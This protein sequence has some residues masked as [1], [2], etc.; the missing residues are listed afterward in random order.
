MADDRSEGP[1]DLEKPPS[2]F[3]YNAEDPIE[4]AIEPG[5]PV[6]VRVK[7]AYA[8]QNGGAIQHFVLLTDG[9]RD[10]PI[11]IG[12]FEAYSISLKLDGVKPDRPIS[13]DLTK[14]I[15]EKLGAKLERIV[16]DDLFGATFYAKLFVTTANE[17]ISIDSRPSD[18]IALALR[19]ECPIFVSDTILEQA[20]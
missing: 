13:H 8:V 19:F 12:G 14:I 2:F 17:E 20:E 6:E 7:G 15:M 18:A 11:S 9:E 16:I 5:V 4:P 3:P 10:L 1:D